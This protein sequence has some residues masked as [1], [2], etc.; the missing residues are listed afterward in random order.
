MEKLVVVPSFSNG[1]E[2]DLHLF[3][4]EGF[5][6]FGQAL[7]VN[8]THMIVSLVSTTTVNGNPILSEQP[9]TEREMRLLLVL[10]DSPHC[11]PHAHLLASLFCPYDQMLNGLFSPESTHKA[12]WRNAIK[13]YSQLLENA[14][15][16]GTWKKQMAPLYKALSLLRPRMRSFGLDIAISISSSAYT[17]MPL[18]L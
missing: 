17:L 6:P 14:R 3:S 15:Q 8:M 18:C 13:E 2:S 9:V 7:S 5:L 10:L 12:V 1:L 11:C 16:L 4:L